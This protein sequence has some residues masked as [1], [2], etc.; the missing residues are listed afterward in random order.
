MHSARAAAAA[1]TW[2]FPSFHKHNQT[3]MNVSDLHLGFCTRVRER[4]SNEESCAQDDGGLLRWRPNSGESCAELCLGCARC[5]YISF[6]QKA[7]LCAWYTHCDLSDLRTWW[8]AEFS[9]VQ[10]QT[11]SV[12]AQLPVPAVPER[13]GSDRNSSEYRLAV[14][15]LS[16]GTKQT[17]GMLGWCQNAHRL[18][19][20]LMSANPWTVD[21]VVLVAP[22]TAH[23]PNAAR[24]ITM[25]DSRDCPDVRLVSADLE[26]LQLI[27]GCIGKDKLHHDGSGRQRLHRG[28]HRH[29]KIASLL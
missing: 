7:G 11:V 27:R 26:L 4:K 28:F 12:R 1:M 15:T 23:S 13:R 20:A 10:W 24:E 21:V 29:G 8:S 9:M 5:R 17:C 18:R 16:L 22:I 2:V 14:A 25:P 19:R 3:S 6:S